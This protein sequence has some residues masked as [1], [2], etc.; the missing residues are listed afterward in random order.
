M[1]IKEL[2]DKLNSPGF[3][4]P[5]SGDL[6]YNFFIY[7]YPI[8]QEYEIRKQIM[9]FKANLIRPVNYV[10][11][12]TLNL[13]EEFCNFLDQKKFLKHPS[14][15][16]YLKDKEEADPTTSENIQNTLTRNAHS[17]EFVQYIHSRII[18]HISIKDEYKRPFVFLY[19]VG[20]MYPYLRVN[21][22]LAQYEDYNETSKYKILVFYP[23]HR[24]NNSFRL[25]GE[26]PDNHTY[27][28]TLL[29]N[30]L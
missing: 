2:D 1:T 14:M 23:G 9:D 13:F 24:E 29:V 19:G 20:S 22:F 30:E 6:F 15:L 5:K 7:Q 28:A 17:P 12:L 10:D 16:K 21:E 4:D 18:E 8:E 3:Q 27:R 26:L 25:F 11:V